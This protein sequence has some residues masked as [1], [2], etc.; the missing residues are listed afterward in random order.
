MEKQ[1]IP[2]GPRPYDDLMLSM[3]GFG[4]GSAKRGELV[5]RCEIRSVN[6]RGLD[7]RAKIDRE[8]APLEQATLTFVRAGFERG[9][10]DVTLALEQGAAQ[11][12]L[13]FD[14]AGATRVV[15]DV[16]AFA[17]ARGDIE[18]VLRAGDLLRRPELFVVEDIAKAHAGEL[19]SLAQD[20]V[21]AAVTDLLAAREIEGRA[22]AKELEAR[23]VLT[24]GHVAAIAA[25]A[26][27]APT[28]LREKLTARLKSVDTGAIPAERLA[29][30]VA[31]LAER[32]DV[33]EELAR[34]EMH[35]SH[36]RGLA[37]ERGAV[38]RKLDFLCQELMREANTVG[39]KCNDAET[40][41]FV[42]DLKAEIE[43]I[44]EQ[45]QNVE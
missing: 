18:P 10:F 34:L 22:L 20:A 14:A 8:L 12:G 4:R 26:A 16:L 11:G 29:Q 32:V 6:H 42:V 38:G 25:R 15:D 5:V 17:R 39:S 28:R 23:L 2:M 13:R 19:A 27:D 3:T 7:V 35:V 44:R 24:E 43:R 36:F 41:H 33:R 37:E 40:A 21:S 45:V 31:L 9:R 30:E 1:H